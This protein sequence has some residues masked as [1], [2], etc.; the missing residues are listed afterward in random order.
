MAKILMTQL[1]Y[2]YGDKINHKMDLG[3]EFN[4]CTVL[5]YCLFEGIKKSSVMG[6]HCDSK[7]NAIPLQKISLY[8]L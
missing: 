7:Y 6:W 3:Q 4:F 2:I 8:L 5:P 1:R